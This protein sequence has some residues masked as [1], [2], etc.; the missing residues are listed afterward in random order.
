MDWVPYINDAIQYIE[1]NLLN[2]KDSAEVA[3]HLYMSENYLQKGFQ[4]LTGYSIS[5][6]IRNRRLYEAALEL[7]SGKSNVTDVALKYGYETSDSFSKAFTR[8]HGCNP[9]ILKKGTAQGYKK[10]LPLTIDLVVKGG[11]NDAVKIVKKNKFIVIGFQREI[12][13]ETAIEEIQDFWKE[14]YQKAYSVEEDI[15]NNKNM[16]EKEIWNKC[17]CTVKEN[18]IGEYGII[19]KKTNKSFTYMIAG[20]YV[21]GDIPEGVHVKEITE[22]SWAV[23]DNIGPVTEGMFNIEYKFDLRLITDTTDFYPEEDLCIEWYESTEKDKSQD[24]YRSA[25]WIPV[26][27]KADKR[28]D[29]KKKRL[30]TCV[31]GIFCILIIILLIMFLSGSFNSIKEKGETRE[32]I[33]EMPDTNP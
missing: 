3:R 30:L 9:S 2:L 32:P 15:E 28:K 25:L 24:G 22:S 1:N 16:S 10:F 5:E 13:R 20:K 14:F 8:F 4:I 21:G 7:I 23:F 18:D 33:Y 29:N 26:K 6:Y 11:K 17:R 31:I 27:S 19:F 12:S